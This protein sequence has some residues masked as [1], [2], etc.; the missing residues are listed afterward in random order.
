MSQLRETD[1]MPTRMTLGKVIYEF[2][3]EQ[4][5]QLL[6]T[7]RKTT[8]EELS[9]KKATDKFLTMEEAAAFLRIHVNTLA[10]RLKANTIP[11]SLKHVIDGSILFSQAELEAFIKES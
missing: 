3:D 2:T 8:V 4:F 10:L 1:L 11:R 5:K 6:E 9:K 7:V